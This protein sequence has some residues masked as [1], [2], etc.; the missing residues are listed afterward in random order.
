MASALESGGESR[1]CSNVARG[2]TPAELLELVDAAIVALDA[3][4]AGI[5]RARLQALAEAVRI[6]RHGSGETA[7]TGVRGKKRLDDPRRRER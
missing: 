7:L 5:V 2:P 4:E 6:L 3:G 1:W